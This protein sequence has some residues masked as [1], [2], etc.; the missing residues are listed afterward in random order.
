MAVTPEMQNNERCT[1]LNAKPSHVIPKPSSMA[2]RE[3]PPILTWRDDQPRQQDI[4]LG[5]LELLDE[6]ETQVHRSARI[7][8]LVD[9]RK[10]GVDEHGGYGVKTLP[11]KQHQGE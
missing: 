4:H 2:F 9:I 11:R 6:A 7:Y 10:E 3:V 5:A 8:L 1:H